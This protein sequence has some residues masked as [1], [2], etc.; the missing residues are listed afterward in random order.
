MIKVQPLS[1]F[2]SFFKCFF[3][4]LLL[5][6]YASV[7]WAQ[8]NASGHITTNTTWDVAGSPYV[9]VG[10]VVVDMGVELTIDAGVEV[11][12]SHYNRDIWV[13]GILKAVGTLTDSIRFYGPSSQGGGIYFGVTSDNCEM[14]YAK[15]EN[16]GRSIS[17]YG[18]AIL[19]QKGSDVQVSNCRF[20]GNGKNVRAHPTAVG[21][22][23]QNEINEIRLFSANVDINSHWPLAGTGVRFRP[24]GDITVDSGIILTIVPGV[25]VY[26][27]YYTRDLKVYGTLQAIGTV[28]DSVRFTGPSNLG[29]SV[30]IRETSTETE[31][32]NCVFR[33]LGNMY[34]DYK[35]A[36]RIAAGAGCVIQGCSFIDNDKY[37]IYAHPTSVAG[38]SG[39]DLAWVTL[40]PGTVDVGSIWPL[41]GSGAGYTFIG[42]VVVAQGLTLTIEAGVEVR[43]ARY[44]SNL[45]V[46]G[47]LRAL[48]TVTDSVHFTGTVYYGGSVYLGGT[49]TGTELINCVFERLGNASYSA[50]KSAVRIRAGAACILQGCNF[51]DNDKDDILAHPT[52][53]AGL[54]DNKLTEVDLL[55]DTVDVESFWPVPGLGVKY[56]FKGSVIV[57]QEATLSIEAG[58]KVQLSDGKYYPPD[59]KVYGTLQA[60]GT[61]ADSI[62]FFGRSY[63]SGSVYLGETSTGTEFRNCIFERLASSYSTHKSAVRI[64]AGAGYVL[65]DCSFID[66]ANDDI[67]AHPTNVA[68]LANNDLFEVD[69]VA[70]TIDVESLWPVPGLGVRY[71]PKGDMVVTAGATLTISPGADIYMDDYYRDLKVYGTLRAQG[72]ATNPIKFYGPN[73]HGGNIYLDSLSIGSTFK[74]C[75][76]ENL[77]DYYSTYQSALMVHGNIELFSHNLIQNCW[78]YGLR[79]GEGIIPQ[80]ENTIITDNQI[81]I[82]TE[83]SSPRVINSEIFNNS[84]FGIRNIGSEIVDARSCWWG[85]NTGPFHPTLNPTG[86]GDVVSDR[87]WFNPWNNSSIKTLAV[88]GVTPDT[89]TFDNLITYYKFVLPDSLD[90]TT[91][92]LKLLSDSNVG[93]NELYAD[94]GKFPIRG[95]A[96]Y[97]DVENMATSKELLLFGLSAGIY[98]VAIYPN[99]T[100]SQ[101]LTIELEDL[102]FQILSLSPGQGGNTGSVTVKVSGSQFE[103][104]VTARLESGGNTI[105]VP[106]NIEAINGAEIYA[107]FDLTGIPVG[108]YD[109]VVQKTNGDTAHWKEPFQV[110]QGEIIPGLT[111]NNGLGC[112]PFDLDEIPFLFINIEAAPFARPRNPVL[113]TINFENQGTIDIPVPV[114]MLVS[115]QGQMLSF[116]EATIDEG[117]SQL[118]VELREDGG[119]ENILRAGAS[120]SIQVYARI[121]GG[122]NEFSLLR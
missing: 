84:S 27:D 49:S 65:H 106:S 38:L 119:P 10:D 34:S 26:L 48:G 86:Q 11:F 22:F 47:T 114:R 6:F 109:F 33:R 73:S 112:S 95:N 45:K 100:G 50:Y 97:S 9:L 12:F 101:N 32:R 98:Y 58:V 36:V 41:P 116:D 83:S 88:N 87:V 59:L 69:L 68:G 81:G 71:R 70:A 2:D 20:S 72:T 21:D 121:T 82:Y 5:F 25:E 8:T 122:N 14:K 18:T 110:L 19:L 113:L 63:H 4:L 30:Y 3:S 13:D 61:V 108:G 99:E 78:K 64:T 1:A 17:H 91:I 7:F 15:V 57:A 43:L 40:S 52:S 60:I 90:G 75:E 80:I 51:V 89:L 29:G 77:G 55:A 120:G 28:A 44:D 39:N 54:S 23:S 115:Q 117:A 76:F 66:S 94:A 96:T 67:F 62:R 79:I 56:S 37:D 42:D 105:L 118:L 104:G 111:A 74:F 103:Q 92:R 24:E 107:T 46:Y 93:I 102:G 85:N 31:F 35:S 53:V 16:L